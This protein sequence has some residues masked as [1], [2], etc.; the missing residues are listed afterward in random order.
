MKK[1]GVDG[2]PL[3]GKPVG[4]LKTKKEASHHRSLMNVSVDHTESKEISNTNIRAIESVPVKQTKNA[5]S[6]TDNT[7]V[8]GRSYSLTQ[9]NS[10]VTPKEPQILIKILEFPLPL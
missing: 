7:L 10:C 6:Q 5:F 1:L 8:E 2:S 4:I 3:L 9:L